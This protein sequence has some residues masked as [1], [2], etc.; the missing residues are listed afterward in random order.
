MSLNFRKRVIEKMRA[1][2]IEYHRCLDSALAQREASLAD[3]CLNYFAVLLAERNLHIESLRQELEQISLTRRHCE[4]HGNVR[5]FAET[6]DIE[7]RSQVQ[8]SFLDR[9]GEQYQ[10][11]KKAVK[12]NT[13]PN[14][15]DN[16]YF[17]GIKVLHVINVK[18]SPLLGRLQV[19]KFVFMNLGNHSYQ[20]LL[21]DTIS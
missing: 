10:R 19:N 12:D 3:A 7:T 20:H 13:A 16:S 18:H 15:F 14:I 2:E 8:I 4:L 21:C 17:E 9:S 1:S 11:C 6:V 5:L